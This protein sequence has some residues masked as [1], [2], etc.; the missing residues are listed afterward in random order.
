[1]IGIFGYLDFTTSTT[2][3]ILV[4]YCIHITHDVLMTAG[5][6]DIMILITTKDLRAN[7]CYCQ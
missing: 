1:M 4:N 5:K 6:T 7:T 2:D 3:D